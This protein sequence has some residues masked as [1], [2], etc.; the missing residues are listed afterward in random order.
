MQHKNG[1]VNALKDRHK[2]NA[3]QLLKQLSVNHKRNKYPSV[4]DDS[5]PATNYND[6]TANGL[7]RCIID[8]LTFKGWQAERINN[9]G[10]MIDRRTSYTD[11]M[12]RNKT[13]GGV[14][15]IRGTGTDGTADISATVAGKSVKIEVKI[16]R[17]RQS[18][19]QRKY[20]QMIER[21]GGVYV[22]AKTLQ[23][24]YDWYTKTFE[25]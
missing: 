22:I 15:W 16:G 24:F 7:T 13:I 9:T 17:D 4:P 18:D 10:R 20:Q 14:D 6:R 11:V 8:F 25:L 12:G 21:A 5:L 3:I 19:A 23:G 1:L 2:I